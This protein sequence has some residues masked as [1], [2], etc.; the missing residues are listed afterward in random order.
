MTIHFSIIGWVASIQ[1]LKDPQEKVAR[2]FN[3]FSEHLTTSKR[4][5]CLSTEQMKPCPGSMCKKMLSSHVFGSNC[6][7]T[8]SMPS[9]SP[10][11]PTSTSTQLLNLE[12]S[13]WVLFHSSFVINMLT[14]FSNLT[15]GKI[16][17][18]FIQLS[19]GLSHLDIWPIWPQPVPRSRDTTQSN[20][21]VTR[22]TS[23]FPC[24]A[25]HGTPHLLLLESCEHKHLPSHIISVSACLTIPD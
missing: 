17:S 10:K 6:L 15:L 23:V 24:V 22:M 20:Q 18:L 9:I 21:T 5:L 3:Y 11:K 12:S 1:T 13:L 19:R 16:I 8:E 4:K 7:R 2:V 14:S 25:P